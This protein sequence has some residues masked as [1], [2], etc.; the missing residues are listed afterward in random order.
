MDWGLGY[1][2]TSLSS[3][4]NWVRK[5][6]ELIPNSFSSHTWTCFITCGHSSVCI[7]CLWWVHSPCVAI[8]ICLCYSS[9][10]NIPR[11]FSLSVCLLLSISWKVQ[12]HQLLVNCL[13]TQKRHSTLL[14]NKWLGHDKPFSWPCA[15]AEAQKIW[16]A[17]GQSN[18]AERMEDCSTDG[19]DPVVRVWKPNVCCMASHLYRS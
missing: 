6:A 12:R 1:A 15:V 17:T 10:T 13:T 9:L 3:L 11:K 7:L 18:M 4:R 5:C 2:T 14:G 8:V 16:Q 19:H